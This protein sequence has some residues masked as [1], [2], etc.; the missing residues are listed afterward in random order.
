MEILKWQDRRS[1]VHGRMSLSPTACWCVSHGLYMMY[2]LWMCACRPISIS[3]RILSSHERK[4]LWKLHLD[5]VILIDL[6]SLSVSS[7]VAACDRSVPLTLLPL[8]RL[9][10]LRADSLAS[11]LWCPGCCCWWWSCSLWICSLMLLAS[12]MAFI[13]ASWSPNS[14]VEL[15]LDRMSGRG[16][17]DSREGRAFVTLI[18]R[19]GKQ[20]KDC[21]ASI[22]LARVYSSTS[23]INDDCK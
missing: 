21:V 23:S 17:R 12:W 7:Y 11:R 14:A 1:T 6:I 15:R 19:T 13:T 2:V 4:C 22:Q 10:L 3:I 18:G 9:M 16:G 8:L 5:H 20:N